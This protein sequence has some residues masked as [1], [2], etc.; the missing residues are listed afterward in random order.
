MTEQGVL[1]FVDAIEDDDA[2]VLLGETRH[3]VPRAIL[4]PGAHEGSWLRLAIVAAP[5]EA[6]SIEARRAVLLRGDP[7]GKVKL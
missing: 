5:A 2:W 3:L 1:L 6:Q 7:G 4:P